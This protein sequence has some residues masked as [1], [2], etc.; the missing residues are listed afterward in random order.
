MACKDLANA[1]DT[2]DASIATR[3]KVSRNELRLLNQLE[4]GPRSQVDI[5]THLGV[6]RSAVT[7][8][9]DRLSDDGLVTRQLSLED[10]RVK[11]I[12]LTAK[13]W[14]ALAEHYGPAGRRVLQFAE[15][16][17]TDE[18]DQLTA[19]LV[20]LARAIEPALVESRAG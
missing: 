3:L 2:R 7:A 8:M 16:L 11:M 9:V 17:T 19:H 10:R 6:T 12:S 5:A 1:F 14:Q 4:D 20:R 18:V 13:V 15:P